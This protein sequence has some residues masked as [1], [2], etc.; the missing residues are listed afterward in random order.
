VAPVTRRGFYVNVFLPSGDPEG[1]KVVEKS[2]WSGI[3]LVIPRA[4]LAQGTSRKEPSRTGVY[5]LVGPSDSAALPWLYVGEGDPVRPRLE[6]HAKGKDFWT[7]AIVFTSKDAN[8]NKAHVQHLEAR[9]VDL[10]ARAKRCK[11]DNG[12]KPDLPS[13]SESEAAMVEG[14]LDD[15]LLC[16]PI[17]GYSL[18]EETPVT[19]RSETTL[20]LRA[21]KIEASGIETTAGFVVRKGSQ[22]V[23][24]TMITASIHSYLKAL[25]SELI[26]QGVL[27][28]TSTGYELTQDYTFASPSTAAGVLLGRPTNGRLDWKTQEGRTLKEIQD[29]TVGP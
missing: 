29:P 12:T 21:K 4:I 7:H 8:L 28:A 1:I 6:S 27:V 3:G 18:F 15:L 24:D 20:F 22:A 17:L 11:L 26:N 9:L 23:S 14:F 25:R 19:A 10:A 16:L 13:L 5:L 2:N